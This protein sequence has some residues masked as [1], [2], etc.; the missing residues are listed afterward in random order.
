MENKELIQV[1]ELLAKLGWTI[2]ELKSELKHELQLG[3]PFKMTTS[4]FLEKLVGPQEKVK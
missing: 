2:V 4:I 3:A 1:A